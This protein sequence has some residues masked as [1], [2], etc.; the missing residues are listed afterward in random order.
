MHIGNKE[1]NKVWSTQLG[2]LFFLL[3]AKGYGLVSFDKESGA[4]IH[5]FTT[6][7]KLCLSV[8]FSA[9]SDE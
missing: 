4:R 8:S 2:N 5:I 9:Y 6:N 1:K 3:L 7:T